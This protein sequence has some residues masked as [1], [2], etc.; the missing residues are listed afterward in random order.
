MLSL[1]APMVTAAP[2][3]LVTHNQTEV[4][5]NAF[6]SGVASPFPTAPHTDGRVNWFLIRLACMGHIE[7]GFCKSTI[8]VTEVA[9][10]TDAYVTEIGE[11]GVDVDTGMIEPRV[12]Q[13]N[14]F[15][16]KIDGP[17]EATLT[18]MNK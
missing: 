2:D 11:I 15:Q 10:P 16:L 13:A 14:G 12:I 17:G 3:A 1:L 7:G 4:Y 18:Q 6:M 5:A 9:G 8:K